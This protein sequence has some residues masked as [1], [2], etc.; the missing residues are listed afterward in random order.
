MG[1]PR[2]APTVMAVPEPETAV[3]P[4]PES[5]EVVEVVEGAPDAP[6]AADAGTDPDAAPDAADTSDAG[7]EPEADEPDVAKT[8]IVMN[9]GISGLRN[10]ELWPGV[11][12]EISL[13]TEE[14]ETYVRLGYAHTKE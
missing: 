11:G 7:A 1:G 9:I 14:A 5:V 6:D 4:D 3:V 10:G 12:G 13:P 2:K 8:T